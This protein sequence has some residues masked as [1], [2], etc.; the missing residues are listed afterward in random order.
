MYDSGEPIA[1]ACAKL[2]TCMVGSRSPLT[3]EDI[4]RFC[5]P[6]AALLNL[7]LSL[8]A[9][10]ASWGSVRAVRSRRPGHSLQ[11][12][13][14]AAARPAFGNRYFARFPPP[15]L[16][17]PAR[18]SHHAD[19]VLRP[20]GLPRASRLGASHLPWL[21]GGRRCGSIRVVGVAPRGC[22][23]WYVAVMSLVKLWP[24]AGITS[25]RHYCQAGRA[26]HPVRTR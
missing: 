3:D 8:S 24:D 12:R 18:P 17:A 6:T 15:W 26:L 19:A 10:I 11:R 13:V 1:G 23:H 5:I 21:G 4:R 20:L 7:E 9:A 25:L 16:Y 22:S 14:F 2:V